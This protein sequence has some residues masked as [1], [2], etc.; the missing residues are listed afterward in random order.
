MELYEGEV[1]CLVGKM[2]LQHVCCVVVYL[3]APL[4]ALG[5]PCHALCWCMARLYACVNL[6]CCPSCVSILWGVQKG[7]EPCARSFLVVEYLR[8]YLYL[9]MA[10]FVCVCVCICVC[11]EDHC[12]SLEPAIF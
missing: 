9:F 11:V 6:R 5:L 10:P 2:H 8:S 7:L 4:R 12:Q 1:V 3:L